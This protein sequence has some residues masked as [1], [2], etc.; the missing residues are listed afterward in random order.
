MFKKSL[1]AAAALATVFAFAS[2]PAKA[3][4]NVDFNI[5][6]GFGGFG[7]DYGPGYGFGYDDDFPDYGYHPRPRPRPHFRV[8]CGEGRNVVRE[9]GFRRVTAYDCSAPTYGY[10]AWRHG[11]LFKVKVSSNGRI[12]SVRPIW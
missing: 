6:F 2:A 11:D 3:E 4:T 12:I 9:A 10:K 1:I 7:P 8:S 5:G